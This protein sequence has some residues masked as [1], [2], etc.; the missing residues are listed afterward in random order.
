MAT[1]KAPAKKKTTTKAAS[2]TRKKAP[3]KKVVARKTVAR[4]RTPAKKKHIVRRILDFKLKGWV[5]R[6]VVIIGLAVAIVAVGSFAAYAV[7]QESSANAG[8]VC[9][10]GRNGIKK[11]GS[12]KIKVATAQ[13][14]KNYNTC[15][16]KQKAAAV[17]AAKAAAQKVAAAKAAAA[18][19]V[20][21]TGT[22]A[23]GWTKVGKAHLF[24][25]AGGING[26]GLNEYQDMSADTYM[27]KVIGTSSTTGSQQTVGIKSYAKIIQSS[28]S[29]AQRVYVVEF[30]SP[31]T[32]DNPQSHGSVV[33]SNTGSVSYGAF[34]ATG[35]KVKDNISV[36]PP[37][38]GSDVSLNYA[39]GYSYGPEDSDW[40][41][42]PVNVLSLKRCA[43]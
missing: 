16:A 40:A 36:K 32:Q 13:D 12:D 3:A 14:T 43:S 5:S 11:V 20:A 39:Y 25:G 10:L 4:K 7:Y 8:G 35:T 18:A 24:G 34:L 1:K 38:L 28:L 31:S 19:K 30:G 23:V 21:G 6:K 33:S 22:T 17:A 27:C 37:L 15:V 42:S 2:V 9:T 26:H 41:G 29:P